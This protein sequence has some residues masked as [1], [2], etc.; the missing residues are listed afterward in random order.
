MTMKMS[1]LLLGTAVSLALGAQDASATN[2][3]VGTCTKNQPQYVTIQ[4]AVNAAQTNDTVQICPGSYPEQVVVGKAITLTNV[5]HMALPTVAIPAGGAVANTDLLPPF[6]TFP[7]AAQILVT[8][9]GGK[10]ANVK[11]LIVDGT[12]NNVMTCGMELI[13]IYYQNAGG[14]ISGNTTQNQLLPPGYQGCQDG[15]GIFVETQTARTPQL[16]ISGNTVN[17]FNKNGITVSYSAAQAN[18]NNNTVTGI[19]ATDVIAQNGIQL[20]FNATGTINGN[21]VSNLVYSPATVGASG[22]LLYDSVAGSYLSAPKVTNNTVTNAQYGIVLDAVNGA[23]GHLVPIQSN[24]VSG[25]AFAGVGLY[26]DPSVPASDDYISVNGNTISGTSPYDD[27]D[28]CSDNNTISNN[29]VSTATEGG[30]HLDGLCTE[31]DNSSTGIN[32]TVAGNHINDN[33]VGIL[34]GPPESANTVKNNT[35]SGNTNDTIYGSDSYSCGAHHKGARV[36][37]RSPVQPR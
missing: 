20:G 10:P 13:G 5:P 9:P 33:C 32:N 37:A 7:V 21:K 17:T 4:S 8:S 35:F 18:I 12:G 16:T 28:V 22:I 29:T 34:S 30:I 3:Q 25:A 14:T 36:D 24:K 1:Y 19:G 31:P 6:D 23:G 11:N 27:I 2:R 15:E 26:S